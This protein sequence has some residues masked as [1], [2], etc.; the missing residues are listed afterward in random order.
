MQSIVSFN[1]FQDKKEGVA[2][3]FLLLYKAGSEVS[4]C[5]LESLTGVE[6]IEND[7]FRVMYADVNTVRDI[8]GHYGIT[9][10]PALLLFENGEFVNV[11]K[12][13]QGEDY[14]RA[15]AENAV[16]SAQT[17]A[18]DKPSKS[19]RVYTTPTCSWCN[20]LKAFLRKNG[21]NYTEIDVSRDESAAKEMVKMSGQQGVPQTEINGQIIVGFNQ[22]RLKELLEIQG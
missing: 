3:T 14:Y 6:K 7:E 21:V 16:Y 5:A 8:H 22:A 13:C 12:G 18:D 20:T 9:S 19:V 10:V 4:E 2:R 17:N 1:D 11:I 15:I